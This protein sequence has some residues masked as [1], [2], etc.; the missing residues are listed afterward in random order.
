MMNSLFSPFDPTSQ[1]LQLN[2]LMMTMP[3]I[4]FPMSFWNFKSRLNKMINIMEMTMINEMKKNTH[5]KEILLLTKS[6]FCVILLMNLTGLFP[7]NFTTT[8]HLSIASSMALPMWLSLMIYSWSK[9][10]NY[11]LSH[12]LPKGSPAMIMPMM[13][14]IELTGMLIRPISLSMRLTANMMAGHLMMTLLGNMNQ[15]YLIMAI[16]PIKISLMLFESAISMIQ[17]YIFMTLSTLY[18]SEIP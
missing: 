13:V 9:Y 4:L 1:L 7:Y 10:T 11:M 8:S 17:A 16:L 18:S 2:W 3:L 14:L 12:L 5:N 15:N 6:M